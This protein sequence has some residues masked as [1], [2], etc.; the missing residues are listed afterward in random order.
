MEK[1][2]AVVGHADNKITKYQDFAKEA[3]ANAHVATHGGFVCET[4]DGTLDYWVVDADK[5]TLTYDKSTHDSDVAAANAVAYKSA[6]KAAYLEVNEQLDQL[7]H[8]MTA[9]KCDKSGD[10]YAS[11]SKV[12]S[13]NPKP[14]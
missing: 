1:F 10:W 11:I 14:E 3:D 4:P 2:I 6:R 7:Y 9:D 5:K 12:K 13:D 8:D